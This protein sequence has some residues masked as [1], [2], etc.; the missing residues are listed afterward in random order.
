MKNKKCLYI[1]FK[2]LDEL[3]QETLHAIES[4]KPKIQPLNVLFFESLRDFR[5][6][7]TVQKLEVLAVIS[8]RKPDSV[9]E[10]A[11]L[12]DRDT[13]AV[14][15]DCNVLMNTGFITLEESNSNRKSK[16]PRLKFNYDRI[17]V[18][19]PKLS[20]ELSFKIAA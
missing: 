6:F 2:T 8:S 13:S 20:Y 10:L 4:R 19:L 16:I 9:Y 3:E 18:Q 17:V 5:D 7:M 1:N 12:L 11:Q 14:Q 15:R